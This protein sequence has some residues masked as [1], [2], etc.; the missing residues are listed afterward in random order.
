LVDRGTGAYTPSPQVRN[1]F[2]ST[3]MHNTVRVDETEQNPFAETRLWFMP[4]CAHGVCLQA[5][6]ELFEGEHE[7]YARFGSALVHRRWV[8]YDAGARAWEIRDRIAGSGRHRIEVFWHFDPARRVEVAGH[9]VVTDVARLEMRGPVGLAVYLSDTTHSASYGKQALAKQ[10][11]CIVE[12]ELPVTL[13]A[14]LIPSVSE[15]IG[16]RQWC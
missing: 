5:S 14:R 12:T 6:P 3:R 9:S 10:V 15:P 16:A 4:N 11:T 13:Q 2:R 1:R 8:S 7:G